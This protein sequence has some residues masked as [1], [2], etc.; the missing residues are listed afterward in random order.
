MTGSQGLNGSDNTWSRRRWLQAAGAAGAAG[1]ASV[2]GG[3][4]LAAQPLRDIKL[5]WGAGAVCL[6]PIPVAIERGIF[7][8]H[9]LKA[10]LVNFTGSTD[11][12]LELL[13]TGKADVGVGLIHRW[14]KPLESGL[15]VKL[16]GSSH[17]GC[18]RL[19]GY[20]PAGIDAVRKLKGRTIAVT[21]LNSP[22]KNFFSILLAKSGI[23]PV[24]DVDWRVFPGDMLGLALEKGEAHAIADHDPN[25]F[26]IQ[27]RTKGLVELATN[28]SGEYADKTCCVLG[29][30]SRLVRSDKPL[31]ASLVRAIL[32]ASDFVAENPK[33]TAKIFEAYAVKVTPEQVRTMLS[34]MDHKVHP[35]GLALRR[36]VEFYANDFKLVGVLKPTTN[37]ARFAEHVTV[38][39]LS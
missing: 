36:Q 15:D 31:L 38:D 10:E 29:A 17:G 20:A 11:Q 27:Q 18:V 13:A 1:A 2:A 22:G 6:A 21:D 4:V 25:L 9:G 34:T 39:V 7:A 32:E 8:R 23:D 5:S 33:E 35:T 3:K 16:I 24:R 30:G 37:A 19:L 12:L 28:M 14:I 26:L